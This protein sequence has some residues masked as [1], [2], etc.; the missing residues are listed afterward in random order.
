MLKSSLSGYSHAKYITALDYADK[1]L[2]ALSGAS[3]GFFCSFTIVIGSP[4]GIASA[5]ICQVFRIS[6]EY[7]NSKKQ[8]TPGIK[9]SVNPPPPYS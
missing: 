2:L 1:T 5:S 6:N 7:K 9:Y 8:E 3:S 4:V